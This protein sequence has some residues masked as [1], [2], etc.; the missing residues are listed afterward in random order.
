MKRNPPHRQCSTFAFCALLKLLIATPLFAIDIVVDFTHDT[1]FKNNPT[2]VAAIE[3]A[4]KDVSDIITTQLPAYDRKISRTSGWLTMDLN[5]AFYMGEE[6]FP[7]PHRH[8]GFKKNEIRIYVLGKRLGNAIGIADIQEINSSFQSTF[9]DVFI[10][11]DFSGTELK[12]Q[13]MQEAATTIRRAGPVLDEEDLGNGRRL[14]SGIFGGTILLNTIAYHYDHTTPVTPGRYDL[15]TVA[16]HEIVHCIGFNSQIKSYT[17]N[18]VGSE[19]IGQNVKNLNGGSGFGVL[20]RAG[21]FVRDFTSTTVKS[22]QTQRVVLSTAVLRSQRRFLTELDLAVLK[23][24]GWEADPTPQIDQLFISRIN[25]GQAHPSFTASVALRGNTSGVSYRWSVVPYV[26]GPARIPYQIFTPRR[27]S[28]LIQCSAVGL[29]VV[30]CR[31]FKDGRLAD[32]QSTI[33]NIGLV[34][35]NPKK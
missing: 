20:D 16:L 32:S 23:D 15:Y 27:S 19:W 18:R 9:G 1:F 17:D 22:G 24:V 12:A 4:A 28:T 11:P 25:F 2:A 33:V 5:T 29:Y 7:E 14:Q 35:D 8:P 26:Y 6:N 10:R 13:M 34:V 3:A 21:H 30:T 31:I